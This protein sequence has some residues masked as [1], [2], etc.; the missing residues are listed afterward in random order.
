MFLLTNFFF[1]LPPA[2]SLSSPPILRTHDSCN[3]HDYSLLAVGRTVALLLPLSRVHYLFRAPRRC[4]PTLRGA[5]G[6]RERRASQ[7]TS[8]F[9]KFRSEVYLLYSRRSSPPLGVHSRETEHRRSPRRS[10][11]MAHAGAA[12]IDGCSD[13]P[14]S[15]PSLTLSLSISKEPVAPLGS[16][17]RCV[18]AVLAERRCCDRNAITR[19][20]RG[21]QDEGG[22]ITTGDNGG[23][24]FSSLARRF[25]LDD[26][27]S[28]ASSLPGSSC[29]FSLTAS[30]GD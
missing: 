1:S 10:G 18:Y 26:L 21:Y 3:S 22:T 5:A 9:P 13:A 25:H 2:F 20:Y 11:L 4:T 16:T 12:T 24:L 15:A 28:S 29:S 23:D 7:T 27:T 19:W 8:F 17:R 30:N 14:P 6:V